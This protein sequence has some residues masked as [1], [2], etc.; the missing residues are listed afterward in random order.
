MRNVKEYKAP[1]AEVTQFECADVITT[2]NIL[3]KSITGSGNDYVK[4]E[5][6]K[7]WSKIYSN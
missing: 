7:D 2:S 4:I 6:G 5:G 3:K 1:K